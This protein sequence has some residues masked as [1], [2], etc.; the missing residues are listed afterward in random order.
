MFFFLFQAQ[1]PGGLNPLL[2]VVG[3]LFGTVLVLPYLLDHLFVPRVSLGSG[4]LASLVF[5][6]SR[7]I[8]EYLLSFTPY[9]SM[10]SLAYT[11]YGDLPLLQVISLTGIYG[12]SF[13]IAWFASVGNW[14]WEQHIAWPRI[15][16]VTLL[17]STT[18]A[19]VLLGGSTRLA[20]FSP[21]A[22]TVRVA[23]ISVPDSLSQQNFLPYTPEHLR[24]VFAPINTY[25]V[26][27]T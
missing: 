7:V 19:L 1:F 2:I 3:L 8:G 13:L 20:F 26:L 22:Q 16:L 9:G 21:S 10:I 17:Y 18:L 24:S 11:Q 23:G 4:L 27:A 5:P 25:L 12:V 15:R 14:V 6:F